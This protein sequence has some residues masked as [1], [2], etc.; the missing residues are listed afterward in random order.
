MALIE[1]HNL[2]KI[3]LV[4]NFFIISS[5]VQ[6][7]SPDYSREFS[8]P[9]IP[10]NG[11]EKYLDAKSDYI[12]D[13]ESLHTFRLDI[14]SSA[15]QK[16]D[17]DPAKEE[18]VEGMLIFKGDT[19]SPVGIR[20]KGSVGAFVGC[21]TGSNPFKPS[22]KKT[23]TKLSVKVKINWKGRKQKFYDLTK[24]Q[25]HSQNNCLLYTSPS[26]RDRG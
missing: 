19:L 13:Q 21:L 15:L 9:D 10:L 24:L 5:C 12:F 25:F 1:F 4:F 8:V 16:I 23:C 3:I 7:V 20:Y 22:G 6:Q 2:K 11:N 18:Y 17:S 26:P 14:P